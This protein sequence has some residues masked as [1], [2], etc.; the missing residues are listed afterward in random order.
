MPRTTAETRRE[1]AAALKALVR[2]TA[3]PEPSGAE[4]REA[5]KRR[6]SELLRAAAEAV[7]ALRREHQDPEVPGQPDWAGRSQ[8]YREQVARLYRQAQVPPDSAPGQ[9]QSAIRYHVG[10][11]L[12]QVAPAAELEAAG[13]D[14]AG[15]LGRVTRSRKQARLARSVSRQ[16]AQAS[17]YE[18]A[19]R[20][21]RPPLTV[22]LAEP[23]IL[24]GF[25]LDAIRA[26]RAAGDPDDETRVLL[27]RVAQEAMALL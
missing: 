22:S 11:V 24:A 21:S 8:S 12:R 26:I 14:A 20:R 3:T 6:R 23:L 16:S 25:A 17:R 5:W 9:V 4:A 7:V 10:N 27:M 15:P 18:A 13:L 2:H 1:A 19:E